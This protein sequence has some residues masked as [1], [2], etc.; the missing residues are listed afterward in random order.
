MV[1]SI[2][3]TSDQEEDKHST[4]ELG[5]GQ[6]QEIHLCVLTKRP[7]GS[8]TLPAAGATVRALRM[9]RHI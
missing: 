7:A 9:P 8:K 5:Q 4:R 2:R 6:E 3:G 1:D